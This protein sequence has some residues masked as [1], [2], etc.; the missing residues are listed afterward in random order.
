VESVEKIGAVLDIVRAIA[1]QT[2]LQALNATIE[3]ARAGEPGC[4]FAV[5]AA[6][7]KVLPNQTIDATWEIASAIASAVEEQG[8]ATRAL[9]AAEA[10][11]QRLS[12]DDPGGVRR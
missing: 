1:S 9:A 10:G 11:A 8:A 4:G 5:V 2:N 12:G 3:A 7:R 6:E